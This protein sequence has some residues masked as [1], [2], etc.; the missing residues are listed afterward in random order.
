MP[1]RRSSHDRTWRHN[2][3]SSAGHEIPTTA[4][5]DLVSEDPELRPDGE[6]GPHAVEWLDPAGG[7]RGWFDWYAGVVYTTNPDRARVGKLLDIAARLGARVQGDAG[8]FY[9]KAEDWQ[10]QAT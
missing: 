7:V 3:T 2:W 9:E 4:W 6:N 5:Q 10:E 8:E 1:P